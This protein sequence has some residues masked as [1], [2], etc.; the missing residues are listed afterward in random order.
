MNEKLFFDLVD[1]IDNLPGANFLL[2]TPLLTSE[3]EEIRQ[4]AIFL[5]APTLA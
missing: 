3:L 1:T 5:S 4:F 2:F